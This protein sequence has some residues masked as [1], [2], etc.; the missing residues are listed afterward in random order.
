M[1]YMT[2]CLYV[3]VCHICDC[4]CVYRQYAATIPRPFSV[5]YNP[6]TQSVEVINTK[7]QIVNLTRDIKGQSHKCEHFTKFTRY[8][9]F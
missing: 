7:Q 2:L 1:L 5:R 6:Y 8:R 3:T 4:L 9:R